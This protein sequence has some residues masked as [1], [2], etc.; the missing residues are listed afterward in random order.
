MRGFRVGDTELMSKCMREWA[1]CIVSR[2]ELLLLMLQQLLVL[3]LLLGT[4]C[5]CLSFP[6][7]AAAAPSDIGVGIADRGRRK[8][9]SGGLICTP[10][11]VPL[12]TIRVE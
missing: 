4:I 9:Q 8:G 3:V 11:A 2:R 7:T 5:G 10:A 12:E 1:I 6:A